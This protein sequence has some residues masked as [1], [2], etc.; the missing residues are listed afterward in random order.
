MNIRIVLLPIG[1]LIA[2]IAAA[3]LLPA[4]VDAYH[5]NPDWRVFVATAAGTFTLGG[6]IFLSL[7]REPFTYSFRE[8]VLFVNIAWVAVSATAALPLYFSE[9]GLS[10]VDA[11][12]EAVSGLTTTGATVLTKLDTAPPGLLLWRSLLQW[13]GGIGIVVAGIWLLPA[14]RVGGQQLFALES[15]DQTE[16]PFSRIE[17]YA[18]A[19][20]V[21]YLV[22][23]VA[24]TLLYVLCGMSLFEAVNHAM[25]TVATGGYSTSDSS[26]GKFESNAVLWV[27]TVFMVLSSLP[28]IFLLRLFVQ[29][30]TAID[31]QIRYF[32]LIAASVMLVILVYRKLEG[33]TIDF[34][35]VTQVV[36]NTVSVI[37][38]TGYASED[39]T[40]WGDFAFGLIFFL[41]FLGG[42][43]GST[44]GGLKVFRLVVIRQTLKQVSARLVRPNQIVSVRYGAQNL[45]D[46]VAASALG[47]VFVY[48]ATFALFAVALSFTELDALTAISASA[49]AISNV[50][51]GVGEIIGPSGNFSTLPDLAK[52]LLSI[53]MILGRL[54]LM[55]TF[56]MLLPVFWR[57]W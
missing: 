52:W 37:T 7:R 32:L 56:V 2:T 41:T 11:W 35:A 57:P 6:L 38:T 24:C 9:L 44:A 46:E 21:L 47:F 22:I 55:S 53:E 28:F 15:S 8:A 10:F 20:L 30:N 16:K 45:S 54:E 19:L 26:I 27:A 48:F 33:E 29:R 13:I 40:Q 50:G 3:M 31:P 51:P 14:L 12:F 42:C 5:G 49:T 43:T 34:H 36:F 17:R 4:L 23:T 18:A 1:P 25:T 39:Y